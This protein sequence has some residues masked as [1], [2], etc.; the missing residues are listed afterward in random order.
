MAFWRERDFVAAKLS[1]GIFED[2][3]TVTTTPLWSEKDCFNPGV[4]ILT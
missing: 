4:K 2:P 1:P 3:L